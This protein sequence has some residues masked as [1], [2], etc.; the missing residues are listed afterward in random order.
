MLANI[1]IMQNKIY[2]KIKAY[3]YNTIRYPTDFAEC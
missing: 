3:A 2:Q 1:A